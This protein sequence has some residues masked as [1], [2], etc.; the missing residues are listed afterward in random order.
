M[1]WWTG[2]RTEES[3]IFIERYVCFHMQVYESLSVCVCTH[4][5]VSVYVCVC[6]CVF[7]YVFEARRQY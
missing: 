6:M 3:E 1:N 4:L 2:Q 5:C 7:V